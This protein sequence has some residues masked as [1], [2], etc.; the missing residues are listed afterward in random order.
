MAEPT[1]SRLMRSGAGRFFKLP[2]LFESSVLRILE[3]LDF[4]RIATFLKLG[5]LRPAS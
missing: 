1:P 4:A 2:V 3:L 5:S